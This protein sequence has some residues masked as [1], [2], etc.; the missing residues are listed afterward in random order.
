MALRML[1][2]SPRAEQAYIRA[3]R[4]MSPQ[5]KLQ[6][7]SELTCTGRALALAQLRRDFPDASEGE[8]HKRL[9]SRVLGPEIALRVYGWDAR[10]E[11]L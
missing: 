4:R 10:R 8:L 2:T 1:D 5:R 9:A 7:I 6:R 11:G 3:I